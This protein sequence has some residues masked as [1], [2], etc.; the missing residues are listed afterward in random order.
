MV[1]PLLRIPNILF[2]VTVNN[3]SNPTIFV[4]YNDGQSYPAYLVNYT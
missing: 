4:V 3:V 1:V 2:D